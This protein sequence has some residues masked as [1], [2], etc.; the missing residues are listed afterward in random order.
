MMSPQGVNMG[1]VKPDLVQKRDEKY[2]ISSDDLKKLRLGIEETEWINPQA[3]YWKKTGKGF[4]MDVERTDM[5]LI[6][7]FP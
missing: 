5:K 7:P 3:D 2:N 1:M 6:T 4:A